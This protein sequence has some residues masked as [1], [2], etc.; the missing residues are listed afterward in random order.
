MNRKI[1][2]YSGFLI[3]LMVSFSNILFS[4][5]SR[6]L[7]EREQVFELV[8]QAKMSIGEHKF[9]GALDFYGKALHHRDI[10]SNMLLTAS[11]HNLMGLAFELDG[12]FQEAL[13]QFEKGME[14]LNDHGDEKVRNFLESILN[15]LSVMSKGYIGSSGAAM[16]TDL[17]RGEIENL[18]KFLDRDK[19]VAQQ[20]LA[21]LLMMNDG[22]MYLQQNQF[23]QADSIYIKAFKFTRESRFALL[24]QQLLNNLTWSGIKRDQFDLANAWLDS[25]KKF[26]PTALSSVELRNARLAQGIINRKLKEYQIAIVNIKQAISFCQ[27]A[28]DKRGYC[29]A[30]SH[31][32]NTYLLKDDF[33]NARINYLKALELN[34]SVN[35]KEA[36]W[37]AN[38]GLAKCY[39]QLKNYE[40]ALEHFESY[41]DVIGEMEGGFYRDEGKTSFLESQKEMM[42][43]YVT[44]TIEVAQQKQQFSIARPIIEK[45]RAQ[46]LIA[47]QRAREMQE[48]REA[49]HLSAAAVIKL[50]EWG[51]V[52]GG[53]AAEGVL[54]SITG[55]SVEQRAPGVESLS[56]S[57][58]DFKKFPFKENELLPISARPKATF[59]EYY[60]LPDQIVIL[61]NSPDEEINGAITKVKADSLE[62]L[63]AEFCLKLEAGNTRGMEISRNVAPIRRKSI[64]RSLSELSDQLYK[65]LI[66][67]V[68]EY[69]PD[70]PHVPIVIVPH[71]RL[72]QLPFAALQDENN[73]YFGDQHALTYAAS[74]ESW[75]LIAGKKRESDHRNPKAWIMGNPRMPEK[76]D[77]CW[78][79]LL[80][81]SLPGAEIEAREIAGLFGPKNANLFT[82]N[83]AD[84]LRLEAW[85]PDF[86]VLHFA[87]HGFT[88]PD[89]PLSSFVVFSSLKTGETNVDTIQ[90]EIT[91]KNDPRF[92]VKLDMPQQ[93]LAYPP[94]LVWWDLS[95]LTYSGI[96][97]ARTIIN[98]FNLN[99]D[100]VTLSACQTGLGEFLGEGVIGFSRAFLGAGARSLLVSLWRVD[101]EATK[102][103]MIAFYTEY[104][105]HGNKAIAL[106]K[107][108]QR[109]RER[110]PHPKYWAAFTL[111]G[112]AE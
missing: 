13:D 45:L 26:Y 95:K 47:L 89:D 55:N 86:S 100:L 65:F 19:A 27:E 24:T 60:I 72:W 80:F 1:L 35:D 39:Y 6:I 7:S 56:G 20:E 4:Q 54:P 25:L 85:H 112:M 106:Q 2:I 11:I 101:D 94:S 12:R 18:K 76:I 42:D 105:K 14:S 84:R 81:Q 30:L 82:G 52:P 69:L 79:T 28:K 68:K 43:A 104:L 67:P 58:E 90:Y 51:D 64:G 22:N 63:I 46:S 29:R 17:Y 102:D 44:T 70:R 15:R 83:Q 88:C 37:F 109:T 91:V 9:E 41:F 110:F 31:L 77:A 50:Q 99:A 3:I 96:L 10:Q 74:H 40:A 93:M 111:I 66:Q 107:A 71:H 33:E 108:M 49:G 62:K 103:L 92:M 23:E 38:A 98:Q 97:D 78:S 59:L 57:P 5:E 34:Q 73:N 48:D 53:L 8:R 75:S 32:A 87:T 21:I 36:A 16:S 61:V